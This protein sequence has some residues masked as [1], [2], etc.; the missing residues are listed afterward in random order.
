VE[1]RPNSRGVLLLL[2]RLRLYNRLNRFKDP[3]CSGIHPIQASI[4]KRRRCASRVTPPDR[5]VAFRRGW[6]DKAR[7]TLPGQS[8]VLTRVPG[9]FS[10]PA[11]SPPVECHVYYE[12]DD[13]PEKCTA[14]RLEKFD[15]AT[16]YRSM[17][18]VPYGVVLNPHAEQALSPAD[19]E[20]GWG[21]WLPSIA[22]GNPPRR[23][24][25]RCAASTG[26]SVPRR[27]ESDQLRSTVPADH[28]RSARR[29][30]LHL[31][32]VGARRGPARTVPLGRDLSDA[33]REPLRRYSECT[34]SSEVVAVQEDYLAD[35]E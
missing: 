1:L 35:E 33:Q 12:G 30:V 18:Q 34:D 5:E 20:E 9:F 6:P 29:R 14:R 32:R 17:G 4:S 10:R 19:L 16:L 28:R 7:K 2:L 13:D 8:A 15:K 23:R 24:R 25:S 31:R 22:R 26:R 21:R 27:R 3:N 11:V